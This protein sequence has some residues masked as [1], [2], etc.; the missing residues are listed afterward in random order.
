MLVSVHINKNFN[1]III[2]TIINSIMNYIEKSLTTLKKDS[3]FYTNMFYDFSNIFLIIFYLIEK[4]KSK[5][6]A[7]EEGNIL[8]TTFE[9]IN[10]LFSIKNIFLIISC[11]IFKAYTIT[12]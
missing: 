5:L 6:K 11:L 9:T 7:A 10:Q 8:E 4:Y 12:I 1:Y 3:D 2:F